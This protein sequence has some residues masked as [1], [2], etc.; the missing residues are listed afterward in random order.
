ME[1]KDLT[2]GEKNSP[3]ELIRQAV[4]GRADLDKLEKLL[5]IQEKW[6]ANEARKA[7]NSSMVETQK[8]MPVVPK[9]LFNAHTKSKY[10]GLDAIIIKSKQIYTKN[11]FSISFYE[12][13]TIITNHIRVCA[14]V[15][16]RE[17]HKETYF[18]DVPLDGKGI[19]GNANM[20]AI[21]AK[22]SSISYGQ[23]YLMC[24]IWNIPTGDDNDGNNG[25]GV[26]G[27]AEYISDDQAIKINNLVTD[28]G[29]NLPKL[30]KFLNAE[31]V[32]KILASQYK[33]AI[34][35]LEAHKKKVKK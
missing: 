4:A 7:F 22:S 30:L 8:E 20:T 23:R 12:G 31:N 9:N 5:A 13:N 21:H 16:H 1:N 33:S 28:S 19:Q 11:G 34:N 26:A 17:G 15:V 2:I 25:Q 10:A 18:Y 35:I 14:D 6:E 32:S 29:A 24:L 27:G 3:A